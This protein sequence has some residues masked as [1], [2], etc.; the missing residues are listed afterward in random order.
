[1]DLRSA[2]SGFVISMGSWVELSFVSAYSSEIASQ[3]FTSLL[4]GIL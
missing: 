3:R 4:K 1:M 2:H